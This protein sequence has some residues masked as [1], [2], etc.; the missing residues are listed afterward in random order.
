MKA[1]YI[2]ACLTASAM[3]TACSN[4]DDET[5][6]SEP[7]KIVE[8]NSSENPSNPT[9]CQVYH[10]GDTIY[11]NYEFTDNQELGNFALNIHH[12]FDHHNHPN[13]LVTCPLDATKE[14]NE[15]VWIFNRTYQIPQGLKDYNAKENIPI[16]K[17]IQ[18]GDYHFMIILTDKTGWQAPQRGISIKILE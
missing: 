5:K 16:P 11:F 18:A 8:N 14:P 7:P 15:H 13:M 1:S 12:N 9:D 10:R 2:V 4:D 17:D 6:D 3:L